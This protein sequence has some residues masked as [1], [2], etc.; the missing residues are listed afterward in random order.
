ME[1]TKTNELELRNPVNQNRTSKQRV[2][3]S[4]SESQIDISKLRQNHQ[5]HHHQQQREIVSN[6]IRSGSLDDQKTS[7]EAKNGCVI[8]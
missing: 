5:L 4:L 3:K 8:M 2:I 6:A 7:E 1:I